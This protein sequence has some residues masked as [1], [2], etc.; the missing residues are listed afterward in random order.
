MLSREKGHLVA[1][2]VEMVRLNGVGRHL[3]IEVARFHAHACS[4]RQLLHELHEGGQ[5]GHALPVELDDPVLGHEL[6]LV[7]G[8]AEQVVRDVHA[9]NVG[10]KATLTYRTVRVL[11][12]ET[13]PATPRGVH[14]SGDAARSVSA[15]CRDGVRAVVGRLVCA[16]FGVSLH[17]ARS[18]YAHASA[19]HM[20]MCVVLSD[21]MGLVSTVSFVCTNNKKTHAREQSACR[22]LRTIWQI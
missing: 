9:A 3:A 8:R 6:V 2:P 4:V 7:R 19:Y 15:R 22:P 18:A 5:V 14:T 13:A 20:A 21:V 11:Q 1:T 12:D 17:D 16:S 10:L